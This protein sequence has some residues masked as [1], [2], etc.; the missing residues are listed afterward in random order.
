MA[1]NL[2]SLASEAEV[3]ELGTAVVVEEDICWLDVS[4]Y[5]VGRV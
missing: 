2:W 5:D 1:V 3:T 4:V